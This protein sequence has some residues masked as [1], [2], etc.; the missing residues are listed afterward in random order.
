MR[1]SKKTHYGIELLLSLART[2]E[3]HR[4]LTAIAEE[5]DL[6]LSFLKH[7]AAALRRKGI[8]A[9]RGGVTGGYWLERAPET[10]TLRE[11]FDALGEEI[12]LRPPTGSRGKSSWQSARY[13]Q[14][15]TE[16]LEGAFA[17]TTLEMI[18]N[19]R[20]DLS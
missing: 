2:T 7:I 6:P 11:I 20:N 12:D 3:P 15:V 1:L 18:L 5:H 10:V 19:V 17:K 13:W 16:R 4:S 8:L 9:S 14:G